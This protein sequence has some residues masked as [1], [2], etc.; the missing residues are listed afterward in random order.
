M[1]HTETSAATTVFAIGCPIR[2][3]MGEQAIRS[4]PCPK[5][6]KPCIHLNR[7]STL[8]PGGRSVRFAC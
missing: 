2:G 5:E 7:T 1:V 6:G 8:P 3:P 4:L